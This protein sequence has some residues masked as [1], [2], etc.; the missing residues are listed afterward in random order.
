MAQRPHAEPY[1]DSGRSAARVRL[2]MKVEALQRSVSDADATEA[3][4]HRLLARCA[5]RRMYG[6]LAILP[7]AAAAAGLGLLAANSWDGTYDGALIGGWSSLGFFICIGLISI[8]LGWLSSLARLRE[9]GRRLLRRAEYQR[10]LALLQ[11]SE[12]SHEALR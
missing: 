1:L 11:L 10:R 7:T 6:A 12:I 2:L 8:A 5:T 3:R 4:G 9:T